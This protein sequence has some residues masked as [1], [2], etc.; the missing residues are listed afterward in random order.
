[1]IVLT[2]S[3]LVKKP[4]GTEEKA[5]KMKC[6]AARWWSLVRKNKGISRDKWDRMRRKQKKKLSWKKLSA[7]QISGMLNKCSLWIGKKAIEELRP[8]R[9]KMVAY[10]KLVMIDAG[11]V[12]PE[13]NYG[14]RAFQKNVDHID[15]DHSN[16]VDENL[17]LTRH[18]PNIAR[19]STAISGISV[20]RNQFQFR[21]PMFTYMN[22]NHASFA[23]ATNLG[24]DGIVMYY[25]PAGENAI[26][27]NEHLLRAHQHKSQCGLAVFNFLHEHEPEFFETQTTSFIEGT[28]LNVVDPTTL[29]DELIEAY[30]LA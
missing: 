2:Q 28:Q 12:T 6:T 3:Y 11:I 10:R 4:D 21:L 16:N 8:Y 14:N 1:L 30:T 15:E 23:E 13:T 20:A 19:Q 24:Y 25:I 9:G 5:T 18:E 7:L 22:T 26:H 27:S 29:Y 17:R